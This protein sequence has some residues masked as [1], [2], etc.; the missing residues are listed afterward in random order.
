MR[1]LGILLALTLVLLIFSSIQSLVKESILVEI[2]DK[3]K[4]RN[5]IKALDGRIFPSYEER[6]KEKR[7]SINEKF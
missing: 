2:E 6:M 3:E 7:R 5:K 1:V 4:Q